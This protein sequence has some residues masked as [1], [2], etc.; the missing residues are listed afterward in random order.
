MNQHDCEYFIIQH[1]VTHADK[2]WQ[3]LDKEKICLELKKKKNKIQQCYKN[4]DQCCCDNFRSQDQ[5]RS[6]LSFFISKYNYCREN[7]FCFKYDFLNHSARSCKSSFNF[8]W[9]SVKNDKIKSQFYK[10]WVRK[11]IKTQILHTSSSSNNDKSNHDVHI[12]TDEDYKSD[13]DKLYK[14]SKN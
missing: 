6:K 13:S 9:M 5:N 7:N 4:F 3:I 11:S 2:L 1:A 10:T 8:D 14:C 12:T